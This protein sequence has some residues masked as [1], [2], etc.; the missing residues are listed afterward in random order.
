MATITPTLHKIFDDGTGNHFVFQRLTYDS[1]QTTTVV[2]VPAGAVA[3]AVLVSST[4]QTAAS[5]TLS[6]ANGTVTLDNSGT[7]GVIYVVTRHVGNA[8]GM[9]AGSTL[10]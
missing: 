2:N 1:T 4:G 5:A 6:Q 3:A 7:N 8:G 9:G 10:G